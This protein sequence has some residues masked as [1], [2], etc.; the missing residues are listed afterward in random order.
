M[1][2]LLAALFIKDILVLGAIIGGI[3]LFP[4]KLYTP[5]FFRAATFFK[6]QA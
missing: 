4:V 6:I 3:L 1:K 2:A 5:T